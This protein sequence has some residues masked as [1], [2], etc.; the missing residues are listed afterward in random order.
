MTELLKVALAGPS[1]DLSRCESAVWALRKFAIVTEDWP[2]K[3]RRNRDANITDAML[4]PTERLIARRECECG[5]R[6]SNV[7]LW[8]A[9]GSEGASYE[10]GLAEG[11][12]RPIVVAGT[13]RHP[14]YGETIEDSVRFD[15]DDMA[16]AYLRGI[17]E[18]MAKS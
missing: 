10:C 15:T 17:A 3:V 16:I 14:I 8:L 12:G 2:A 5:I 6:E 4:S 1:A 13:K 11:I 18:R 7:V 9:A